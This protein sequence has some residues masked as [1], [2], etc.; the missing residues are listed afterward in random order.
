MRIL[1]LPTPLDLE[2]FVLKNEKRVGSPTT[3]TLRGYL[4]KL[5][6]SEQLL[7]S[8]SRFFC[9]IIFNC[10]NSYDCLYNWKILKSTLIHLFQIYIINMEIF[11]TIYIVI[12]RIVFDDKFRY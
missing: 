4:Y 7:Y 1:L 6:S 11:K 10:I 2:I 8:Y 12:I 9:L 3:I 5:K